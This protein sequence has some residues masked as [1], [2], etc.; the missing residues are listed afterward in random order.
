MLSFRFLAS[1][2][3]DVCSLA[4]PPAVGSGAPLTDFIS[5]EEEKSN[6]V[7]FRIS[8]QN[9]MKHF[10]IL[11]YFVSLILSKTFPFVY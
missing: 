4:A 7:I 5:E 9:V 11:V 1:R 2:H 10:M 6:D 3:Q 8:T